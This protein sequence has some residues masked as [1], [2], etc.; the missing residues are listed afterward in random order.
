MFCNFRPS[1]G[2]V[3]VTDVDFVHFVK[4]SASLGFG[5]VGP[6]CRG[7]ANIA[8]TLQI[9]TPICSSQKS[10][11]SHHDDISA[12]AGCTII[13]FTVFVTLAFALLAAVE[14]ARP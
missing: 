3:L 9:S 8:L 14:S 6:V 13:V 10:C 2:Y 7:Q 4:Q 11:T 5:R 1:S 12:A